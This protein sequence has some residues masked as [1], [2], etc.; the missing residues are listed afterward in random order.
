MSH[1]RTGIRTKVLARL[2][3]LTLTGTR[4]FASRVYPM[5]ASRLPGL[6][7]YTG[8]ETVTVRTMNY[9]RTQERTLEV[10]V[11]AYV[12]AVSGYEST[13]DDI[14]EDVEYAIATDRTLSGSVK[15]TQLTSIR[16]QFAGDGEQP[17]AVAVMTFNVVYT[18]KENAPGGA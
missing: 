8:N 3:N 11:E 9:P 12:R 4:V 10:S 15:D 13:L 18:T 17:C 6:I 2:A 1:L 14:I 5:D 16:S 7:V